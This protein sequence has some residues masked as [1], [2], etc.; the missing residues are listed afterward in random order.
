MP[1]R[2]MSRHIPYESFW[3]ECLF[4]Y[5]L[6]LDRLNVR[7]YAQ[8]VWVPY[9]RLNRIFVK[10]KKVHVPDVLNFR[11]G[12]PAHL[13]QVKG[14]D[15]FV[16]QEPHLYEA[17]V[18]YCRDRGWGYSVVHPKMLPEVVKRNILFIMHYKDPR[19]YFKTYVPEIMTKVRFFG[20]PTIDYLAKSFVAK[21][22]FRDVLPLI[23]HLIFLGELKVNLMQQINQFSEVSFGDISGDLRPYFN[24]E[25]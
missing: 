4:Y 7:Y 5:L 19:P 2:K 18:K 1:S 9:E 14:G 6:E 25:E 3:G 20:N 23:Y 8:P 17:C 21:A 16:K 12:F 11:Q 22:D 24:L 15:I 10:E 13:Y